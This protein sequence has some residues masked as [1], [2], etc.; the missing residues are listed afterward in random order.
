VAIIHSY[1]PP[2]F[3]AQLPAAVAALPSLQPYNTKGT[4]PYFLTTFS[5][6]PEP[7]R[8]SNVQANILDALQ[9]WVVETEAKPG[10]ALH[11]FVE[12]QR[13]RAAPG[14]GKKG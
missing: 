14:A 8:M 7:F 10:G 5:N 9:C 11:G 6:P 1:A 2:S 4:L 3:T 13:S 12:R